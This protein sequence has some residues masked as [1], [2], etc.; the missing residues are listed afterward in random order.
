MLTA[1]AY[2]RPEIAA[3][4]ACALL[5]TAIVFGGGGSP[6]PR[7]EL[8]VEFGAA[9]ALCSWIFFAKDR[10]PVDPL[11]IALAGIVVAVP[12][13]QLVPMPPSVWQALPGRENAVVALDLVGAAAE[14]RPIS[15]DPAQTLAS[16]LSL[17][18]PLALM[19]VVSSLR[20]E[21]RTSLLFVVV[22]GGFATALLGAM[23]LVAGGNA[24]RFYG[25]THRDWIVGFQA[26]RNATADV[27]LIA[28]MAFGALAGSYARRRHTAWWL[29]GGLAV[30]SLTLILTG[31]RAG[32]GLLFPALF[33]AVIASGA[34]IFASRRR[35]A[36]A[37]GATGIAIAGLLAAMTAGPLARVASR[38]DVSG[39]FR[40]ELWRDG[41]TAAQAFWPVGGGV[42][43]F[44]RLLLPFERLEVVD[45]TRPNR[46]HNDYLELMVESGAL[47]VVA[48]IAC[49]ALIAVLA[50]RSFRSGAIPREHRIFAFGTVA[51]VALHS[52]VDYP[53]RSMSLACLLA[54]AVA[55]MARP[56]QRAPEKDTNS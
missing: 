8:L 35:I 3:A 18:P 16:L 31:S 37:L 6:A 38:F 45:R 40:F 32:I 27:V 50:W 1:K 9:L 2:L 19:I 17:G 51:V 55:M 52:L 36:V 41:W 11:M 33:F 48:L 21:R 28:M 56:G 43:G 47:G 46:A 26:N 39:D 14:W 13:I 22:A 53:L 7:A 15:L 10:Q 4:I 49:A 30:L 34:A 20:P 23:Q 29:A 25:E 44:A 54:L 42:G 24:L 12:L 5:A